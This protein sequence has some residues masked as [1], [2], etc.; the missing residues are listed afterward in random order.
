MSGAQAADDDVERVGKL[1]GEF[2]LTP[3]PQEPQDEIRQ[4]RRAQRRG[5]CGLD[6]TAA[7]R[8]RDGESHDTGKG[9]DD[10]EAGEP[11]RNAGL[12]DQAVQGGE[13]K[14]IIAA[15]G[16]TAFAAQ[17]TSTLSRS[18]RSF[19]ASAGG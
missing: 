1:R 4:R 16:E 11:D 7:Q 5:R 8:H 10:D 9:D 15:V 2:P 13:F 19:A 3:G 12:Q 18:E 6:D 14:Q 17:A